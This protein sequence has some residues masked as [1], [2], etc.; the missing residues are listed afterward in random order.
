MPSKGLIFFTFHGNLFQFSNS[1]TLNVKV[2]WSKHFQTVKIIWEFKDPKKII[3][4]G[5]FHCTCKQCKQ[6]DLNSK[7]FKV[8]ITIINPKN[9]HMMV[10]T[11]GACLNNVTKVCQVP[12]KSFYGYPK[13][14]FSSQ[15]VM[16]KV[17]N[18]NFKV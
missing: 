10:Y 7:H 14:N 12:T 1:T 8:Q 15:Q 18:Q 13:F 5:I 16:A 6:M 2:R 17:K 9:G 11:D 4:P 3:N